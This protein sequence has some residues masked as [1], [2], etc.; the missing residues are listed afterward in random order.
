VHRRSL[1]G[2]FIGVYVGYFEPTNTY[3]GLEIGYAFEL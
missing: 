2:P 3:G 1:D